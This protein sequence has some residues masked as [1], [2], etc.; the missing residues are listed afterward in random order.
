[1]LWC[2]FQKCFLMNILSWCHSYF[3]CVTWQCLLPFVSSAGHFKFLSE[4][5]QVKREWLYGQY[6]VKWT[7]FT[8]CLL[9]TFFCKASVETFSVNLYLYYYCLFITRVY[10]HGIN[11]NFFLQLLWC[12][13][14][15]LFFIYLWQIAF[16][17][18][19]FQNGRCSRQLVEYQIQCNEWQEDSIE[20]VYKFA[21]SC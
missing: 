5:K 7:Y 17:A 12:S 3:D 16:L 8:I 19:G 11:L 4:G 20:A 15:M 13:V 14:P 21:F 18:R 2:T 1:M 9:Q 6:A 10:L